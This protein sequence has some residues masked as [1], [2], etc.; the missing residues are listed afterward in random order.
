MTNK[1]QFEAW[2]K[3]NSTQIIKDYGFGTFSEDVMFEAWQARGELD[4]VR[5]AELEAKITELHEML[6]QSFISEEQT[7]A[8]LAIAVEALV[9]IR[10]ELSDIC[11]AEELADIALNKI[12]E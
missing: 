12:G 9:E 8:K 7:D 10:D 4:A 1:E 2:Y 6:R 5:I 3:N 11:M